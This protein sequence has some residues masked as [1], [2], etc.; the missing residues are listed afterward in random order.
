MSK[1]ETVERGPVGPRSVP[2]DQTIGICATS[3]L[4]RLPFSSS[5]TT[6]C[7]AG[8]PSKTIRSPAR[9]CAARMRRMLA[10]IAIVL[11][12]PS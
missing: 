12:E 3:S 8:G 4:V 9:A 5:T 11:P 1:T 10:S 7:S 2:P 6:C